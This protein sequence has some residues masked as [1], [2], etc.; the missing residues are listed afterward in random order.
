MGTDGQRGDVLGAMRRDPELWDGGLRRVIIAVGASV[1]LLSGCS[2]GMGGGT[3]LGRVSIRGDAAFLTVQSDLDERRVLFL[4][5]LVTR[6]REAMQRLLTPDFAW[7]E[8][9]LPM[10]ET[11]FDFWDR[12]RLWETLTRLLRGRMVRREGWYV[13]PVEAGGKGYTGPKL[14][15]RKVGEE[16]RLGYFYPGSWTEA[17]PDAAEGLLR[18]EAS[19]P[20]SGGAEGRGAEGRSGIPGPAVRP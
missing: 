12:H 17:E 8:D 13:A 15:W 14:G 7:R 1:L 16:W 19:G 18:K 11:P 5:G 20:V 9:N 4:E 6:D 10:D 3:S 2:S